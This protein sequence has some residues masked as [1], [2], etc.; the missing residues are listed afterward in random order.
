M[1]SCRNGEVIDDYIIN[2]EGKDFV[3]V[4][5]E[6]YEY[7]YVFECY[8]LDCYKLIMFYVG[9]VKYGL[10]NIYFLND[11][12]YI[13]VKNVNGKLEGEW[14]EYFE[15][16]KFKFYSY[17]VDNIEF[18]SKFLDMVRNEF[19]GKLFVEMS[20]NCLVDSIEFY[21]KLLYFNFEVFYI[22]VIF[23]YRLD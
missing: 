20:V 3:C 14:K 13:E 18:Y 21:F 15:I 6:G 4:L 23:E 8:L 10:V 11:F 22:G 2:F 17:F 19:V 12:L 5:E 1:L 7:Y 9:E 16:G